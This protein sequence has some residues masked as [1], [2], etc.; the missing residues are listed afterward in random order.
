MSA[1]FKR[2][3]AATSHMEAYTLAAKL[4]RA[5]GGRHDA[6]PKALKEFLDAILEDVDLLRG[7]A[8][9]FL[10]FV[11]QD[12]KGGATGLSSIDTQPPHASTPPPDRDGSDQSTSDIHRSGVAPVREPSTEQKRAAGLARLQMSESVLQSFKVRDGRA[13]AKVWRSEISGMIGENWRE[14]AILDRL[15][16]IKLPDGK[17]DMRVGDYITDVQM[18]RIINDVDGSLDALSAA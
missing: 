12:M 11:V 6:A 13:I 15:R 1:A 8:L 4:L 16:N 7:C 17:N 5:A 2:A 14:N 10:Q 9:G 3:D 18:L